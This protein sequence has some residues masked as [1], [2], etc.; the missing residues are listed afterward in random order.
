VDSIEILYTLDGSDPRT[1]KTAI[2]YSKPFVLS[3]GKTIR[4]SQK[5]VNM[6]SNV[7]ILNL[8]KY[9]LEQPII[10][11]TK[12]YEEGRYYSFANKYEDFGY[13]VYY[14]IDGS[15]PTS[16]SLIYNPKENEGTV[17]LKD[18]SLVKAKIITSF[19]ESK[20]TEHYD[21]TKIVVGPAGGY[22]FYDCDDDNLT[23]NRDG[24]VSS[25]C[26]WRFLEAAPADIGQA[27]FGYYRE[28]PRGECK[29]IGTQMEIGKG[30]ENTERIVLTMQDKAY[31]S[32]SKVETTS[33][34]AAKLCDEYILNGYDDWFL[35]SKDELYLMY[36]DLPFDEGY[37]W[38]SSESS[39]NYA[40][41]QYIHYG[42]HGECAGGTTDDERKINCYVHAVRAF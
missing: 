42:R 29:I 39:S 5:V 15:E 19:A 37:Y 28:S 21:Y 12:E 22:V 31:V 4:A 16:S 8:E 33:R 27:I 10:Q 20:T 3:E 17:C 41:A 1:S 34:Y 36:R 11:Y 2:K 38:S 13:H 40:W 23:G 24:L 9:Q 18:I 26:G 30:K 25:E 7:V 32:V 35:P 14:T 6:K